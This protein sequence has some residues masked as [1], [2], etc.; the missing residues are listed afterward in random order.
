MQFKK[1]QIKS[2]VFFQ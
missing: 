1:I 2:Q